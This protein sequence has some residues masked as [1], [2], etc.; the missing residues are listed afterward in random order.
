M[1]LADGLGDNVFAE[2]IE[3]AVQAL[4]QD[5][6]IENVNAHRRLEQFFV[7]TAPDRFEQF[8]I[9]FQLVEQRGFLWL[10]LESRDL[11]VGPLIMMPK[12][13]AAARCTGVVA[14]V[15]SAPERMC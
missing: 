4:D 14:S 7:R 5:L 15:I 3:V 12:S 8:A 2:I 10:F 6:A 1:P 11:A 9:Q 13:E